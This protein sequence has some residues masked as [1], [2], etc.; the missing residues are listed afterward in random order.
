LIENME[1]K[2]IETIF[3]D[4]DFLDRTV[5]KLITDFGYEPLL[6]DVKVSALLDELWVGKNS[7]ECDGRVTDFSMLTFL[8]SAP[9]KKLPGKKIEP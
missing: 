7:Y 1:P 6:K 3:M 9:I 2:F 4:A 8:A 5:L